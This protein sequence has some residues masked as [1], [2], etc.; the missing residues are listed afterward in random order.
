VERFYKINI[1]ETTRNTCTTGDCNVYHVMLRGVDGKPLFF[2]DADYRKFLF[3]LNKRLN[4]FSASLYG[5]V[6][7][8]N[9]VHLLMK[10]YDIKSLIN[11][12]TNGYTGYFVNTYKQYSAL[13]GTPKIIEKPSEE[14]MGEN[15]W[16]ILNNPVKEGMSKT[17]G[18]YKYS[19]YLFYTR[20]K[21]KI[22]SLINVDCSF[23]KEHYQSM[24]ELN[25]DLKEDLRRSK[26]KK[27]FRKSYGLKYNGWNKWRM[28]S[29]Q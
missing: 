14:F 22:S 21:T 8:T 12:L 19:S 20:R 27:K 26:S 15:L 2:K 16:Y 4:E 7:M 1:M 9:H 5:F 6:L 11:V 3:L 28:G 10:C 29:K 23:V 17:P 13:F 18:G 25:E 24:S